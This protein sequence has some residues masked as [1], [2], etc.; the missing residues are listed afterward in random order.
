MNEPFLSIVVPC[1]NERDYIGTCV[2]SIAASDY[3]KNRLEVLVV[4]GMSDDGTREVLKKLSERHP[5]VKVLDNPD[6]VTPRAF[7]I[8]V[9]NARGDLILIMSAHAAYA[10]DALRKCAVASQTHAADN[11]GGIWKVHPRGSGLA[12]RLVAAA[13]SDRFGVGN[14]LYRTVSGGA[15]QQVDTVAY[16]CYKKEVFR[17]IGLFNEKLIRGQDMEFNRRLLAAGGKILLVP[18]IVIHY[19]ARSNFIEFCRHNFRN[20]LWAVLPFRLS[21]AI[22]VSLRHLIPLAFVMGLLG[23]FAL[24]L[25]W[26]PGLWLLA[27]IGGAYAIAALAASAKLAFREKDLRYFLL[28]PFT[29]ASLHI[30]YGLGSLW[31]ICKV[32]VNKEVS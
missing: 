29:F 11:V 31:G 4:D 16:G 32:L 27:A 24:S 9:E 18:D 6:R 5:F 25:V 20:G 23:S 21:R 14:A 17:K 19:Y 3:P 10:P 26:T 7:N 8:G 15:P 30:C 28:M 22:P 13:L 1:R 2:E 12:G